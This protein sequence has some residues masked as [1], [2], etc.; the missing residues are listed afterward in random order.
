MV[1]DLDNMISNLRVSMIVECR[2]L[3]LDDDIITLT[4][5]KNILNKIGVTN[6]ETAGNGKQGLAILEK[7][8]PDL[9]LC[10]LGMPEMD[11]VELLQELSQKGFKGGVI[12]ISGLHAEMLSG[13]ELLARKLGLN[14]LGILPKP[15]ASDQL[16]PM[17]VDFCCQPGKRL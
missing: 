8:L 10:D 6:I 9:L 3:I 13:M 14:I 12:L 17:L 16:F 1:N 4:F 5:M 7:S 15:V 11:G 2:I